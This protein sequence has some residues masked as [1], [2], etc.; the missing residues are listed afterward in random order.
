MSMPSYSILCTQCDYRSSGTAVWGIFFYKGDDGQFNLERQMGWCNCCQS[1]TAIE[2]F[3]NIAE[4]EGKVRSGVEIIKSHTDTLFTHVL[5]ALFKSRRELISRISSSNHS[6]SKYIKLAK[7]R[8]GQER[9]LICGSHA[10]APYK[11]TKIADDFRERG[12]LFYHG[13]HNTGVVHPDCG[14]IFYEKGDETRLM[15]KFKTRN[16]RLD[17]SF[18]EAN[19]DH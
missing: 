7:V 2:D 6:Y 14:G 1:I 16:Y 13:Q 18:I 11:P 15:I 3:S 10:V 9:C 5:N 19:S 4:I 17:G 8:A 12:D